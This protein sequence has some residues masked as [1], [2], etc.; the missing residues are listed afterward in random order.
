MKSEE[1][2]LR[3][4]H[5]QDPV[6]QKEIDRNKLILTKYQKNRNPFVE[7]PQLVDKVLDF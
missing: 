4:W 1:D 7:C 6:S 3:R 2:V 5:R